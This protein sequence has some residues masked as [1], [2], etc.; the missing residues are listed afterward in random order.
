[1]L[2]RG[3]GK[4][5]EEVFSSLLSESVFTSCI[6]RKTVRHTELLKVDPFV[7][8]KH[9]EQARGEETERQGQHSGGPR[10]SPHTG[11]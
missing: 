4:S 7:V 6:W 3:L 9:T 11:R 10:R 8:N 5:K 2:H 1:M